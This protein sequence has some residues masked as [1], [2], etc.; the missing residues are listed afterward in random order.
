ME[1]H[2]PVFSPSQKSPAYPSPWRRAPPGDKTTTLCQ[3]RSRKSRLEAGAPSVNVPRKKPAG[4]RRS[5]RQR[6][7]EKAGWKPALPASTFLGKSRLEAG[8]PGVNVPRKK[9]A[10]SRRSQHQRSSEKAG[11][12]VSAPGHLFQPSLSSFPRYRALE[13]RQ[14]SACLTRPA[15]TGLYSTY[16]TVCLRCSS[17]RIKRS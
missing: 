13:K 14:S 5:Q 16:S 8:A 17:L 2:R 1:K 11:W 12:N 7:S 9:P 10:G 15:F 3:T 4:S 6:S